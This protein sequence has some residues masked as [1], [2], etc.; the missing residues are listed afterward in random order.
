MVE[1]KAESASD[2]TGLDELKEQGAQAGEQA[3]E[4]LKSNAGAMAE[5]PL[6]AGA[7][8]LAGVARTAASVADEV[9]SGAPMVAD[10]LKSAGEKIDRL[11]TDLREKKVSELLDAA[12]GFGRAQ[13]VLML[14]G[15]VVVGFALSRLIKAGA[16][17][18][19][20]PPPSSDTLKEGQF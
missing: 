17:A 15:A 7:D 11:S 3:G 20:S 18:Q 1:N 14:A 10:Y 16:A 2:R 12:V 19:V 4:A 5:R 8:A 9:A 13:P 6:E